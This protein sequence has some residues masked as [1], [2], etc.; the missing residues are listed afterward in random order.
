MEKTEFCLSNPEYLHITDAK[1]NIFLGCEQEWYETLWQRRAGCGPTVASNMMLYLHRKGAINL[2]FDVANQAG[3]LS[4]M[5]AMWKHVTPTI[6]GVNSVRKFADGL[7]AFA[8]QYGYNVVCDALLFPK[9]R[10]VRPGFSEVRAFI[11]EGLEMDCPIGFLNLSNGAVKDL[12]SWHW[13]TLVGMVVIEGGERA[14]VEY[15]DG[16]RTAIIDLRTWCDTT[17]EYGG[18]VLFSSV[19]KDSSYKTPK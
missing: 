8:E 17:K 15:Y 18:F 12:D 14:C 3:C 19:N 13:V 10:S 1:G 7:H 6:K 4:L 5:N 2:P 9:K 11:A 16:N